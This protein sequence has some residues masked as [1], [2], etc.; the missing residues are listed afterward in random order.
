MLKTIKNKFYLL[1]RWSEKYTGTDMVY[2]VKGGSWLSVGKGIAMLSAFILSILFANLLPKETYGVY[3]YI[4]SVV[5]IL[6]ISTLSGMGTS[7]T[8]AIARGNEGTVRPAVF[9]EMKWGVIGGVISIAMAIYY[10][11]Q[12]AST[13]AIAFGL[14]G[15]FLPFINVFSLYGAILSGKKRFDLM[16]RFDVYTQLINFGLMVPFLLFARDAY[17]LIVPFLL[18]NSFV[19]GLFLK[20]TIKKVSLNNK[21]DPEAVSYGKHLTLMDLVSV[22][23]T[24]ADKLLIYHF[25]GPVQLAI[26]AIALAPTDQLKGLLK[27]VGQ[28]AFPKF[29]EQSKEV[30]EKAIFKK[31]AVYTLAISPMVAVYIIAAPWLFK[32]FFPSYMSSVI[33]SQVFCVSLMFSGSMLLMQYLQSQSMKAELYKF[34]FVNLIIE[35]VLIFIFVYYYG[36][37][38]AIA[39]RVFF[40]FFNLLSLVYLSRPKNKIVTV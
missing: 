27:M 4:L 26:Y 13:L 36:L 6:S 24:M 35:I 9:A 29:S 3:K 11:M 2:L 33:Y 28:L 30:L 40:R 7:I 15:V 1:L 21:K 32:I 18:I 34:N 14:V 12:G 31:V 39:A 20:L 16:V 19:Q 25:L 8:R 17:L 38:G 5:S 23:A 22:I 37:W 10:W